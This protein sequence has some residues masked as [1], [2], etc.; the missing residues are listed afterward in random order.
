MLF[1][2]FNSFCITFINCPR[3]V[4]LHFSWNSLGQRLFPSCDSI[5][6]NSPQ[7]LQTGKQPYY[8]LMLGRAL[9]N[10]EDSNYLRTPSYRL[11]RNETIFFL[12]PSYYWADRFQSFQP[13]IIIFVCYRL[14]RSDVI[15]LLFG[16]VLQLVPFHFVGL[17]S[18][19]KNVG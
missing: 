10:D 5:S 18:A 16:S 17:L 6:S 19:C 4:A 11:E 3:H 15:L 8:I 9:V 13:L 2:T 14:G 12:K 7:S 1:G